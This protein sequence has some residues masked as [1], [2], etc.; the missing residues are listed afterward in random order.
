VASE[1]RDLVAYQRAVAIANEMHATVARWPSFER[2]STGLQLVRALDSIGANIAE[3]AGRW[4]RADERRLLL[5]ARG[6]LCESEHWLLCAEQR[7]LLQAGS[8]ERLG[9]VAR[10]L[11]G[12]IKKRQLK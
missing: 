1:F 9:E 7:G 3:S 6:S 11:N 4:H 12:L 10:A 5:I 2:W 8:S